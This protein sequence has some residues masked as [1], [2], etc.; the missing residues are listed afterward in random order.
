MNSIK[1]ILAVGTAKHKKI[2]T[3]KCL[4]WENTR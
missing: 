2:P 1:K 4:K 3:S